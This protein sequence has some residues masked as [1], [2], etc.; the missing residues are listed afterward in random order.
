LKSY[1]M[2][3]WFWSFFKRRCEGITSWVMNGLNDMNKMVRGVSA[4][5]DTGLEYVF[6]GDINVDTVWTMK[7][8]SLNYDL[9]VLDDYSGI[10]C[11]K[12]SL[13]FSI[14][15]HFHLHT[16]GYSVLDFNTM[17]Q[18]EGAYVVQGQLKVENCKIKNS[19][20]VAT[21]AQDTSFF[22]VGPVPLMLET[23]LPLA[24]GFELEAQVATRAI[25]DV[26]GKGGF[27]YGLAYSAKAASVTLI[28]DRA[29]S[30]YEDI[31]LLPGG[32]VSLD[33]LVYIIPSVAMHL[34]K[35]VGL[36]FGVKPFLA[37]SLYEAEV[38]RVA[39][40]QLLGKGSLSTNETAAPH[41][42]EATEERKMAAD[43]FRLLL[44]W[45]LQMMA[46][47]E[48]DC[49]AGARWTCTRYTTFAPRFYYL[50]GPN[51]GARTQSKGRRTAPTLR[52]PVPTEDVQTKNL[53]K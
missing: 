45:G 42:F 49:G 5:V 34:N 25:V 30:H 47:A 18:G 15:M 11:K 6:T 29:F 36:A 40:V 43:R 7:R 35:V 10:A 4:A 37:L 2:R 50:V 33:G 26:N 39:P 9:L 12:C 3:T 8:I 41:T 48:I 53:R 22:S 24:A 20:L 31:P 23:S 51:L 16:F 46:S 52:C 14:I 27:R 28:Q 44:S 17:L 13:D 21:L 19:T 38:S 1:S 32:G